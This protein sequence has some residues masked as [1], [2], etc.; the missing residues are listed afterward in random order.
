MQRFRIGAADYKS[1]LEG[2]EVGASDEVAEEAAERVMRK[3]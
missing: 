3:K 1:I 2:S